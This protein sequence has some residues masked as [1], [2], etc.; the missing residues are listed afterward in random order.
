VFDRRTR[1]L[2]QALFA[3]IPPGCAVLDIGCGDGTIASLICRQDPTIRIEGIEVAP[4]PQCL[5]DCKPFDG[6]TIPYPSASFDLCM[7]VDVLHHTRDIQAFLAEASRVSRRYV[8]I[9]DHLRENWIDSVTLQFMDWVGNRPHGV[10]LPYNY[11]SRA[12]WQEHFSA[13]GLRVVHWTE[14]IPLYPFPFSAVFA[15]R[16]HYV[17]LLEKTN[18]SSR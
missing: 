9:K 5:I 16:L 12:Q 2:S 7:F 11:Q 15:R 18:P 6:T 1:V 8:L 17:S 13:T 14:S 4:R 10:I 3:Q